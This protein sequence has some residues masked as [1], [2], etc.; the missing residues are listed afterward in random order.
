MEI[1]DRHLLL[2]DGS[3]T[4]GVMT[5]LTEAVY[6][7]SKWERELGERLVVDGATLYVGAIGESKEEILSLRDDL[8]RLENKKRRKESK[9]LDREMFSGLERFLKTVGKSL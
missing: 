4:D 6:F 2:V 7:K 5:S 9:K 3:F 8:V 1:K